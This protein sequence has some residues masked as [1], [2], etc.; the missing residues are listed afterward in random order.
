MPYSLASAPSAFEEMMETV[1]KG[2]S[3]VYNCLDYVIV[4][5]HSLE[6][7]DRNLCAVLQ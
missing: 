4:T 3:G 5:G 7:H 6:E 2:L 1:L